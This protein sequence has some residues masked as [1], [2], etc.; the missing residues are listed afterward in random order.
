[1]GG[2]M[3]GMQTR[4]ASIMKLQV[5]QDVGDAYVVIDERYLGG[6]SAI[7][8]ADYMMMRAVAGAQ[9]SPGQS[10]SILSLFDAGSRATPKPEL[11]RPGFSHHRL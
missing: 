4:G 2:T 10:S 11:S 7:Q 5:R 6:K 8:I 1:M 9:P 3:T